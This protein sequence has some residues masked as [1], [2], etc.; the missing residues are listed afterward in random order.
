MVKRKIDREIIDTIEKYIAEVSKHY[1]VDDAL[2][3]G[4]FAKGEQTKDSDIDIAVISSDIKDT[5]DDMI[6]L[7]ALRWNV[8]LRIEPHPFKTEEFQA[9]KTPFIN[10]IKKTGVQI[11]LI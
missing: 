1:K 4:S 7:M 5:Y 10:E 6:K 2:L 9:N 8:D 3:F 11:K